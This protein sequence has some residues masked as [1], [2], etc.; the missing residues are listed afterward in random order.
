MR[1]R[2]VGV[3]TSD[4]LEVLG[5]GGGGIVIVGVGLLE[6]VEE[7]VVEVVRGVVAGDVVDVATD[8]AGGPSFTSS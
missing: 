7:L 4:G 1:T 3:L 8:F 2:P 6:L 5:G